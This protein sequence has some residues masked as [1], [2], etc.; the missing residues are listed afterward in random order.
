[1]TGLY[2]VVKVLVLPPDVVHTSG[3]FV[4]TNFRT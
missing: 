3:G 4:W 1:M 2:E